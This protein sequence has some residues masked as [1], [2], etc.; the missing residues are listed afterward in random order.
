M[1]RRWWPWSGFLRPFAPGSTGGTPVQDLYNQRGYVWQQPPTLDF[2]KPISPMYWMA[3]EGR[4]IVPNIAQDRFTRLSLYRDLFDGNVWSLGLT[5]IESTVF[6]NYFS[7]F[8]MLLHHL[9]MAYPPDYD[10]LNEDV[11]TPGDVNEVLSDIII[12]LSR[13]GTALAWVNPGT[14]KCADPR[15]F[16]PSAIEDDYTWISVD[17]LESVNGEEEM[18]TTADVWWQH[19]EMGHTHLPLQ[20]SDGEHLGAPFTEPMNYPG[21][22]LFPFTLPPVRGGFG[23][24]IYEAMIPVVAELTRRQSRISNILDENASPILGVKMQEPGM[25]NMPGPVG[26]DQTPRERMRQIEVEDA[27]GRVRS[28]FVTP[29]WAASMEYLTWDGSLDAAYEQLNRMLTAIAGTTGIPESMYAIREG[30][31]PPSGVSLVRQ[32]TS[33]FLLLEAYEKAIIPVLTEIIAEA[34]AGDVSIQWLNPLMEID[35]QGAAERMMMG[36]D[37]DEEDAMEIKTGEN[38]SEGESD[39]D[40]EEPEEDSGEEEEEE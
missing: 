31:T 20:S 4:T 16:F 2:D 40:D 37:E 15:Y 17:K 7:R 12:D 19:G 10:G 24:S 29:R 36:D 9:L 26:D 27:T 8:S 28:L 5:D 22:A 6:V 18:G 14:V 30:G 3:G 21:R 13:Y 38:L 11:L 25:A 39:T 34:G 35:G 32:H 23:N 1:A 33:A